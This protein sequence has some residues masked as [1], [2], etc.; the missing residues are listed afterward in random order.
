MKASIQD[1]EALIKVKVSIGKELESDFDFK[2]KVKVIKELKLDFNVEVK[3]IEDLHLIN[4]QVIDKPKDEKKVREELGIAI[5][6]ISNTISSCSIIR[7]KTQQFQALGHHVQKEGGFKG[8]QFC[9]LW[10]TFQQLAQ[11]QMILT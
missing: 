10:N 6:K 8:L 11:Q 1:Q 3:G 7:Y 4:S 9:K 5:F 2:V